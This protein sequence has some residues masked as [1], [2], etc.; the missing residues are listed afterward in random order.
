MFGS[1][2]SLYIMRKAILLLF[3]FGLSFQNFL[4]QKNYQKEF[5]QVDSILGSHYD[6]KKPG[7]AVAI[8]KEEKTIYK[9]QIGM[10]DLEQEISISDSTA[11]H[12]ASVS[13]QFTAFLALLL[14]KEGKLS[15]S[16]DIR[17]YLPELKDL[18]FKI[19]LYQLANHTHGLPNLNELA[20]LIGI[21]P[22][23][24]MTHKEAIK[25]LLNIKTTN[26]KP[27][28]KYEYNNTG[29][30]LLAEIIE[31]V[32]EKSFQQA[33]KD[34]V[35]EPSGMMR[36][37]AVD[38]PALIVKNK[39]HSY[40]L[41][42][43]TYVNYPFN[44]KSNGSTG[45]S[46]TI[47]D[48]GKWASMFQNPSPEAKEIF[49]EMQKPTKLNS[50]KVVQYGLGLEFK[51]YKGLNLVFHGGGDSGYR[52]YILHVPKFQFS[53]VILGN[54]NDFTP[55]EV[56]YQIVDTFLKDHLKEPLPPKKTH[57][58]E[59]ELKSFEGTYEMFPGTYY[60]IIAESDTLYFQSYGTKDKA[61]LPVIGDGEFLFPY[62]PTAKLSFYKN[63]FI[64][65][66]ADFK[67]D[68]EKITLETIRPEEVKFTDF[69]GLYK[70]EELNSIFELVIQDAVLMAKHCSDEDIVLQPLAKDSFYSRKSFF[71]KL[72]FIRN[73]QGK[74]VKFKVSG[75][76]LKD[77]EF[78]RIHD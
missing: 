1:Y 68:C 67:Y 20:H 4:A 10:A 43:G 15:M 56:V 66:I 18:P 22:Q 19:N 24:R 76:N 64:F 39:A 69:T 48:M 45:I 75:Q 51:N 12:I 71:G 77:I 60:N 44:L 7:I 2:S 59:R 74:I 62:I 55:L 52:S 28:E 38:S 17:K 78:V 37:N 41:E 34:K 54:N 16:D 57:Y 53:V 58:T 50:G 63:G 65:H 47:N 35:F 5:R 6:Q 30:A 32:E 26:F 8:I 23:D 31:R 14:E 70:N 25:M 40:K 42:H 13:K 9:N 29:L 46:T 36:S 49:Q 27:G 33:L 61:P 72:D 73:T 21:G 3:L 11:F